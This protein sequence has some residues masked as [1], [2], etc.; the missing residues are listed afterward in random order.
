LWTFVISSVENWQP[1]V[2]K[3]ANV[4]PP[5]LLNQRRHWYKSYSKSCN[6]LTCRNDANLFKLS[7]I[8]WTRKTCYGFATNCWF[9]CAAY[10]LYD[11]S[12]SMLLLYN[13]SA[14]NQQ[15]CSVS[16]TQYHDNHQP[17][18]LVHSHVVG[19]LKYDKSACT[20]PICISLSPCF[21]FCGCFLCTKSRKTLYSW[22]G[23]YRLCLFWC[24]FDIHDV[25]FYSAV[26]LWYTRG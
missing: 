26:M 24:P 22:A 18:L 11:F 7:N 1:S 5:Y 15:K 19:A 14:T 9:Y 13:K 17:S 25:F 4:W 6:I 3:T 23:T 20:I 12:H 16:Y 10:L 21:V 2:E 8:S